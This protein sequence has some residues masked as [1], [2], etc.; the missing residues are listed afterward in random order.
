M[1]YSDIN[2]LFQLGQ[3]PTDTAIMLNISTG[4][5]QAHILYELAATQ[6]NRQN[7]NTRLDDV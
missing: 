1:L 7:G 4:N 2:K 3:I 6:F 5:R